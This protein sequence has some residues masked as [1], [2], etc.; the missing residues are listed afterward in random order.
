MPA[1]HPTQAQKKGL[2]GAPGPL[3]RH[4][5]RLEPAPTYPFKNGSVL[6]ALFIA[7]PPLSTIM[8][9]Q[10]VAH[11]A[12]AVRGPCRLDEDQ[13]MRRIV[14]IHHVHRVFVVLLAVL[15]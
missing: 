10:V 12:R 15:I 1:N 7:R 3:M 14:D 9:G 2:N 8:G 13:A 4:R 6:P 11:V 5:R